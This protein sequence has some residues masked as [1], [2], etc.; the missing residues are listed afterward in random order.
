MRS[1]INVVMYNLYTLL[2]LYNFFF[3][4]HI[5]H[6]KNIFMTFL[7]KRACMQHGAN[8]VSVKVLASDRDL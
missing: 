5:N 3:V 8:V 1:D 7:S 6:G 4:N 2:H